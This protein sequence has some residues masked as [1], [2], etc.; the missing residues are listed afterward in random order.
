MSA[1]QTILVAF[2]GSAASG[3]ALRQ[4][5]ELA[6]ACKA[7]LHVLA[8]VVTSAELMLE[9]AA[10]PGDVLMTER[11]YLAGAMANAVGALGEMGSTALTCVCDGEASAEIIA[12]A[13]EIKAD[14]VVVGHTEK[15]LFAS[16]FSGKAG[17]HLLDHLPC[18]TLIA[19]DGAKKPDD[20]ARSKTAVVA[21]ALPCA[22]ST[23]VLQLPRG[24]EPR[25]I[26]HFDAAEQL[27]PPERM[28][29]APD[30]PSWLSLEQVI[31]HV[32]AIKMDHGKQRWIKAGNIVLSPTDIQEL[33]N[34]YRHHGT[35]K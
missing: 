13:H 22:C 8:V 5:A 16:L 9:P 20:S 23:V 19:V 17:K 12:Y 24:Q 2:D 34:F 10:M 30:R 26:G 15:G 35:R 31:S 25:N 32:H 14:L 21:D 3:V 11:R 18:S 1:Y 27:H 4:G 29:P 28:Q 6:H 33:H 7:Q